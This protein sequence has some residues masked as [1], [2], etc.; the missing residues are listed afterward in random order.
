MHYSTNMTLNN[1]ITLFTYNTIKLPQNNTFLPNNRL[2][3]SQVIKTCTNCNTH[4]LECT[5]YPLSALIFYFSLHYPSSNNITTIFPL[6]LM[7]Q[8]VTNFL[9]KYYPIKNFKM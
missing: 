4:P 2:P 3:V 9:L 7:F 6:S 5:S 8:T 1:D